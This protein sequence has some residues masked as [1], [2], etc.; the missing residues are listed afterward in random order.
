[1]LAEA[2]LDKWV[3]VFAD[4]VAMQDIAV[5]EGNVRLGNEYAKKYIDAFRQLN[6]CGKGGLDRLAVLLDDPR[7]NV[8][9]AAACH[10]LRHSTAKSVEV[11]KASIEE[12]GIAGLEALMTLRRW[13]DGTWNLDDPNL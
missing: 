6:K 4:S 8:R 12:K 7:R 3:C 2:L 10:L 9:T 13:N 11:L 5:D 1:M